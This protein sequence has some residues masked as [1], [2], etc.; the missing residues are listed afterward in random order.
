MNDN[1]FPEREIVA[2][3]QPPNEKEKNPLVSSISKFGFDYDSNYI[4]FFLLVLYRL[5]WCHRSNIPF[6]HELVVQSKC[7]HKAHGF[8]GS[9]NGWKCLAHPW[10]YYRLLGLGQ[11]DRH[12]LDFAFLDPSDT[13]PV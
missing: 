2:Q 11:S 10:C 13:I 8:L 9:S 3:F 6:L 4:V 7:E 12:T 5:C 1:Y